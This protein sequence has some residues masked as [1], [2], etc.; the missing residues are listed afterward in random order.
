MP[1]KRKGERRQCRDWLMSL[2]GVRR[3]DRDRRARPASA[4]GP[5]PAIPGTVRPGYGESAPPR[6]RRQR[7]ESGME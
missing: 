5:V 4:T 6:E 2:V 1:D 3:Q 7:P